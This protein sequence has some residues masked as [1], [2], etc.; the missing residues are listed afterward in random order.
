VGEYRPELV[1]ETHQFLAQTLEMEG[2][3]RDAEH[4]YVEAQV[5]QQCLHCF[6]SIV[7]RHLFCY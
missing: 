5:R 1:K 3:L 7:I 4:H 2:S 6:C